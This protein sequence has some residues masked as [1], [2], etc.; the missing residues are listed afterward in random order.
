MDSRSTQQQQQQFLLHIHFLYSSFS[1][2]V[3][4]STIVLCEK[5]E[6]KEDYTFMRLAEFLQSHENGVLMPSESYKIM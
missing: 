6:E 1:L 3:F 5:N 4:V 2:V